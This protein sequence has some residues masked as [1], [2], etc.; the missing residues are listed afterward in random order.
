MSAKRKKYTISFKKEAVAL[1]LEKGMTRHAVERQL[2][3]GQGVMHR[4]VKE[5]QQ[6][7]Q[8][9]F[10]GNGNVKAHEREVIQLQR[11]NKILK[12]ELEILKKAVAIFSKENHQYISL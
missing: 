1:V 5:F 6:D 4:W 8:D 9:C 12:R 7:P 2:G 11:Q 3:L 10:P